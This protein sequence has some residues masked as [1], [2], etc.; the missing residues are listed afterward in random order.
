MNYLNSNETLGDKARWELQK[1]ATYYFKQILEAAH[2]I[3]KIYGHLFSISKPI[4]RRVRHTKHY[5][6][7]KDELISNVL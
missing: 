5:S 1:N 3:Q 2:L 7:S 6:G 4:V